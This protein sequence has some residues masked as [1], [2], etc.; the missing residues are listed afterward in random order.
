MEPEAVA[1]QRMNQQPI[2]AG[3]I[4]DRRGGPPERK[5]V[6]EIVSTW[7]FDLIASQ[8]QLPDSLATD[9]DVEQNIAEQESSYK[10]FELSRSTGNR[11]LWRRVTPLPSSAETHRANYATWLLHSSGRLLT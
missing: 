1:D 6:P 5:K 9:S 11:Q 3:V 7:T 4:T 8:L 2:T 10:L